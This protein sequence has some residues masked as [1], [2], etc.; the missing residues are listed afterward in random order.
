[1]LP[2]HHLDAFFRLFGDVNGDGQ[3]DGTDQGAFL[4][5]LSSWQGMPNYRW[6]FDYFNSGMIDG[7]AF[8]QFLLRFGDPRLDPPNTCPAVLPPMTPRGFVAPSHLPGSTTRPLANLYSIRGGRYCWPR[9]VRA[10]G[11]GPR[12]LF[13]PRRESRLL[14]THRSR[15][16]GK[17]KKL[18]SGATWFD[19]AARRSL[20]WCP[21]EPVSQ[22]RRVRPGFAS[23]QQP[24]PP[25][26]LPLG[27][28]AGVDVP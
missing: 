24:P 3:V 20:Q 4:A 9:A 7:N 14:G 5:A 13:A 12:T 6:C 27:P 19:P 17:R 10:G 23:R 18:C 11:A 8:N 2:Y 25:T 22:Q 16:P 21:V 28:L 15:K 26:R 1:V